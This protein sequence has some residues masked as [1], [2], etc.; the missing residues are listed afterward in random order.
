[1]ADPVA[2]FIRQRLRLEPVPGLEHIQLY[3]AHPGSRLARLAEMQGAEDRPPPY[4]AYLWAGGL[5]T[6]RHVAAHPELV[7]GRRVL[8]LGAGGGVA[9]IAA[10][11]AGA[12]VLAAEID[13][14][15]RTALAL[16]AAA[17]GV[18]LEI[19]GEDLTGG[20]APA[21][22][23]MLVSDLFY[24]DDLAARVLPFLERCAAAGIEVLVGD[25]GR[26]PLPR[27]RLRQV[28]E[29]EVADMGRPRPEPGGVYQL[30]LR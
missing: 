21:V 1:M 8:D 11:K 16:N 13:A 26:K 30:E 10:A 20:G 9:A 5:L 15:G 24:A 22:E 17:N 18:V 25:P 29:Y 27:H 3:L 23:V 28:A 4:W 6:A 2:A 19:T 7:R 14:N 12:K